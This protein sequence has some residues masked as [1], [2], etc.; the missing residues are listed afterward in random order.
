MTDISLIKAN[1]GEWSEIYAFFK[2]LV[3]KSLNAADENLELDPDSSFEVLKIA[4]DDKSNGKVVRK[5]Y[6][7]TGN[8]MEAIVTEGEG[9]SLAAV[10]LED[11]R[12]GVK[13][14]FAAIT[15]GK[16]RSF[17]IPEA[18]RLMQKLYC[19]SIKAPSADKSDIWL[20][21]KDRFSPKNSQSG[22]SIKTSYK[23]MPTLFNASAR[24]TNFIYRVVKGTQIMNVTPPVKDRVRDVVQ[25]IYGEGRLDFMKVESEIFKNNLQLIDSNFPLIFATMLANYHKG[26]GSRIRELVAGLSNDPNMIQ[27]GHSDAFYKGIVKRFLEAAAFGMTAAKV[28]SGS[29]QANGGF[30][31][32][33]DNGDLAC[34][35]VY[36]REKY[37]EYLFN[38]TKFDTPDRK[39]HKFGRREFDEKGEEVLRLNFQV[40]FI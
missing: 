29:V 22:F 37:L 36:D 16:G 17:A 14:V 27:L 15:E 4:R 20:E 21:L 40:R 18:Q 1:K 8:Q 23:S 38:N 28:W 2:L 31:V 24:N 13:K 19:V 9:L 12:E 34:Y 3:E 32:V 11:L 5:T 26:E 10:N 25:Q 7:L 30:I 6:D 33:K 35:H 39:K